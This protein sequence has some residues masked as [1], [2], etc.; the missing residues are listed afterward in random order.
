MR[1][2]AL[3]LLACSFSFSAAALEGQLTPDMQ[4]KIEGRVWNLNYTGLSAEK[5]LAAINDFKMLKVK[6]EAGLEKEPV[7][8][9]KVEKKDFITAVEAFAD[10]L[11]AKVKVD[12]DGLLIYRPKV[13]P[14]APSK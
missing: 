12:G 4:K 8:A 9:I 14:P 10:L 13:A 6:L 1:L 5:I 2:F 11:K 7:P 3:T